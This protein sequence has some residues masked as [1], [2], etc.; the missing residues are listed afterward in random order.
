MRLVSLVLTQEQKLVRFVIKAS[1]PL[2]QLRRSVQVAQRVNFLST[3]VIQAVMIRIVTALIAHLIPTPTPLGVVV[4]CPA[5]EEPLRP[6][7]VQSRAVR[8]QKVRRQ[9][10]L[11]KLLYHI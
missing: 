5:Q 9:F 10:E 3:L 6:V 7:T 2:N 4:V 8:V 11:V 1:I